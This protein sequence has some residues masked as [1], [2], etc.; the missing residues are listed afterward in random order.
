MAQQAT[1]EKQKNA[2]EKAMEQIMVTGTA[3]EENT[4]FTSLDKL[5]VSFYALV[6]LYIVLASWIYSK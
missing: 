5:E 6:N 1:K 2:Q 3:E 4:P